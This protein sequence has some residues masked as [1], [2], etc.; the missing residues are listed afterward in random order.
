MEPLRLFRHPSIRL[1]AG[2][3]I[4]CLKSEKKKKTFP[5]KFALEFYLHFIGSDMSIE[6]TNSKAISHD[7]YW[8][9]Y[10]Y[11]NILY[12]KSFHIHFMKNRYCAN[13]L[14]FS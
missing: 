14:K 10:H 5:V 12:E 9:K 7:I 2:I 13:V 1:S 6:E 11:N 4:M 3:Q 8:C